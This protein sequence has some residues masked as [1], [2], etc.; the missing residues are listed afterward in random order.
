V[1]LPSNLND[2]LDESGRCV[3]ENVEEA[4]SAKANILRI[5]LLNN[6]PNPIPSND[7]PAILQDIGRI[8]F[9]AIQRLCANNLE[10]RIRICYHLQVEMKRVLTST[11]DKAQ[12][13]GE[14][15][16]ETIFP[17]FNS[18]MGLIA[19]GDALAE[20]F[21]D[22][23]AKASQTI[24]TAIEHFQSAGSGWILSSFVLNDVFIGR[25]NPR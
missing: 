4:L 7:I 13:E 19:P 20:T 10:W 16:S 12:E 25:F 24:L 9:Q 11:E 14:M 21:A 22:F 3:T 1:S 6:S 15:I 5:Q 2:N 17:Y 8:V 23:H 18:K